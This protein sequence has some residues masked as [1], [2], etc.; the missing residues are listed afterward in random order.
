MEVFTKNSVCGKCDPV[1]Q[2][3]MYRLASTTLK[4]M[5]LLVLAWLSTAQAVSAAGGPM[6][7]DPVCQL[8]GPGAERANAETV[9]SDQPAPGYSPDD[10]KSYQTLARDIL[11]ELIEINTTNSVGNNT[12]AAEAMARRLLAA[13]FPEEDVEVLAPAPSK[14]NLVARYRGQFPAC[15]PLL[16]LAHLD[17]VEADA[18]VWS[19]DPFVF[20][21]E[22]G[23]FYGRGISDDKDEA[24]IH[25]ANLIRLKNAGYKPK[26]DIVVALTSDE[27]GGDFNGVQW[28]L[29]THPHKLDAEYVL[30]EGGGGVIVGGK[31]LAN[32]VQAAEKQYQTYRIETD[33]P[34]G[35]SSMPSSDNAIYAMAE[36]LRRIEDHQ[37]PVN[38]NPVTS[39]FFA[40]SKELHS[41]P[42]REAMEGIL[43]EPPNPDSIEYLSQFPFYNASMRTT[44]VPTMIE[45][46]HAENALPQRVT[47]T[48]NCR[49]LPT[50]SYDDVHETMQSIFGDHVSL[51]KGASTDIRPSITDRPDVLN[52]IGQ[53]SRSVWPDVPVI[54]IMGPGGTDGKFLRNMGIPVFGVNGIFIDVE[55]DRGHAK[56]ERI[57]VQSFYE[58]QEFL[59]RL[60]RAL[61]E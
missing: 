19:R 26:R 11:K 1:I 32:E 28:L 34:G 18:D 21:E 49:L 43:Q 5:C 35:H 39:T 4:S 37:F 17:V 54:P 8:E 9:N 41:G 40:R 13:G 47:T 56:N 51:A 30:N 22:G 58:G 44:C 55:D 42:F 10:L 16:L 20:V 46:G 25:I 38:L 27:E 6:D 23:Y 36:M 2:S 3:A 33:S 12:L 57:R 31:R 24:A 52:I 61:S 53:V 15:K 59:Y 48:I 14:G 50:D 60:T 45:G 29:S 7:S